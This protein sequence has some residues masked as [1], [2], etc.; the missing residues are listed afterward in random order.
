MHASYEAIKNA[1]LEIASLK[2]VF[3]VVSSKLYQTTPVSPLPQP[4]F[5]NCCLRL[6]T[7]LAPD[8]LFSLLEEIEMKLGKIKKPK[9]APRLI[10]ID[11]LLYNQ[12]QFHSKTLTLPHPELYNRLFVL[13]PLSELLD[14]QNE[15][16][17]FKNPH[18]EV[19]TA[20]P[21]LLPYQVA[22]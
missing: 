17:H 1:I 15:I 10:D 16:A 4:L 9:E 19:V 18:Q 2:N 21:H 14:L 8:I 5:L 13:Q 11:L 7:T 12:E 22:S 6:S 3:N 20:L